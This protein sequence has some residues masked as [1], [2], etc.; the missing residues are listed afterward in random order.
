MEGSLNPK[1]DIPL[2][3]TYANPLQLYHSPRV[4]TLAF[5]QIK[6]EEHCNN[7]TTI[8]VSW[9]VTKINHYHFSWTLPPP[10]PPLHQKTNHFNKIYQYHFISLPPWQKRL[11]FRRWFVCLFVCLFVCGQHYSKSYERIGMK[12]YGGVLDST[13]KNRLNFGGDLGTLRWLN[14]QKTP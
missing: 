12:F 6:E 4:K 1:A 2:F 5:K 8:T 14:E 7:C 11:F 13:M 9:I 10:A 3:A